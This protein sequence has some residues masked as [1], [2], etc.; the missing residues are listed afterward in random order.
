MLQKNLYFTYMC[1]MN[2]RG[3]G[4]AVV[5]SEPTQ[6]WEKDGRR[7]AG[8]NVI[9]I[10]CKGYSSPL[11][12]SR[13]LLVAI[14]A[15]LD[16]E[17]VY[18]PASLTS[19]LLISSADLPV[20]LMILLSPPRTN[21]LPFFSQRMAGGGSPVNVHTSSKRIPSVLVSG[22]GRFTMVGRAVEEKKVNIVPAGGEQSTHW[23]ASYPGHVM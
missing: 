17:Q 14:P 12:S 6:P 3:G 11:T 20:L 18:T 2:L 7:R 23:I 1:L 4:A 21:T 16:T 19:R 22:A 9:Y 10:T 13:T 8:Q 5:H 15:T